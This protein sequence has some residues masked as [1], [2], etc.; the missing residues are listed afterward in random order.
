MDLKAHRF[1]F[2]CKPQTAHCKLK[3]SP[4]K[5]GSLPMKTAF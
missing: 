4:M 3:I 1:S 5:K 2:N